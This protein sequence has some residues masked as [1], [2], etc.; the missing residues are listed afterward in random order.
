VLEIEV[1]GG[2]VHVPAQGDRG[3]A[4]VAQAQRGAVSRAQL[5]ALGLGRGAIAHRLRQGRLHPVHRGVYLVG[6]RVAPPLGREFAALLAV[7]GGAVVSHRS[8]ARLWS[9]LREP[10]GEGEPEIELTVLGGRGESRRGVRV[11]RAGRPADGDVVVRNGLPVT[12]PARTLLDLAA[13]ARG[14][15]LEWAFEEAVRTGL[16]SPGELA[17]ALDRLPRRRGAPA[18][19]ALLRRDEAPALTRSEAEARLRDL[20]R[21]AGLPAPLA[22]VR[23]AGHEVDALWRDRRLV[24]E[25]DGFAYHS[26]RAAFERDRARD[27]AL[28]AAGYRVIR[29]TWRQLAEERERLAAQLAQALA[30]PG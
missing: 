26:S 17:R 2:V 18:L 30:S 20:I 19:R 25:V 6:H 15:E 11:H 23:L 28:Q 29:V 8:A 21:A 1:P 3:I 12:V 24:V 16:T 14:R 4:V 10:P 5:T 27:A 22:N 9:M 13:V 7:G